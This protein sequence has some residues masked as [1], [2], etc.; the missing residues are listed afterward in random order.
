[1]RWQ[2]SES[3]RPLLLVRPRGAVS[4]DEAHAAIEAWEFY[5]RKTLDPDQRLAVEL[6]MAETADRHWA[7]LTTGRAKS[8]QNGKGDEIEVPEFWDLTVRGGMILHTA[9]EDPTARSA[10]ERMDALLDSHRDLRN[11]VKQVRIANGFRAIETK[12]AEIHYRTRTN[13][14]GRGLDDISR[15]VVD[16]AQHAQEEQLSSA[17]NTVLANPNPQINLLGSAGIKGRSEW[18]WTI[19]M[20]AARGEDDGFSYLEHSAERL[21]FDENGEPEFVAPADPADVKNWWQANTA[22]QSGR[23][24]EQKLGQQFRI[25]G[26]ERFAR[27]NL[28]VWDPPSSLLFGKAK[29]DPHWWRQCADRAGQIAGQVVVGVATT[30]ELSASALVVCGR[31]VDGRRRVEVVQHDDGSHWVEIALADVLE[32]QRVASVTFDAAGPAKSLRPMLERVVAEHNAN[33][34]Q[35]VKLVPLSMGRYQAACASFVADVKAVKV[36]HRGDVVLTNLAVSAAARKVGDGWLW[37]GRTGD[38][39]PLSAATCAAAVADS[40]PEVQQ[41]RSVYE[42]A[43]LLTV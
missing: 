28:C 22:L 39:T 13:S 40:L 30:F 20:Q 4:L 14:T 31:Q 18:W 3:P 7:A 23:L 10:H 42:D 32:S 19:R 26:P 29:I 9:H 5:S 8:R 1:M 35:D 37:E 6:M 2:R 33:T 38:V 24:T 41:Q 34:R 43:D 16:E 11:K 36:A 12:V 17:T 25:N 21:E 15:L 27:E